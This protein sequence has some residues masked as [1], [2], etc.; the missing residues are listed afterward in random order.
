MDGWCQMEYQLRGVYCINYTCLIL[1][2]SLGT[3]FT[4]ILTGTHRGITHWLDASPTRLLT[5]KTDF[6][7]WASST[8]HET[9]TQSRWVR[10]HEMGETILKIGFIGIMELL[11][12]SSSPFLRPIPHNKSFT[13]HRENH[14]AHRKLL[15]ALYF[16]VALLQP[17]RIISLTGEMWFLSFLFPHSSRT[18]AAK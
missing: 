2:G 4:W 7:Q 8:F 5:T 14:S 10:S 1:G 11:G 18:T 9:T 3:S 13:F 6:I 15:L 17:V 16:P 12:C